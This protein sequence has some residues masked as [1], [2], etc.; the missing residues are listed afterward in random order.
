[1]H[2]PI[3]QSATLT[4]MLFHDEL[5]L[6]KMEG[7]PPWGIILTD[8]STYFLLFSTTSIFDFKASGLN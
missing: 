7:D 2:K 3:Y 4:S 8:I 1:M 5:M 6:L